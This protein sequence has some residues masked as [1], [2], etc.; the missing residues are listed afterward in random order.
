MMTRFKP[1]YQRWLQRKRWVGSRCPYYMRS[2]LASNIQRF[3]AFVVSQGLNPDTLG[4]F[5]RY[6]PCGSKGTSKDQRQVERR[7][8][9]RELR[10]LGAT[11]EQANLG[12]GS[13]FSL[14]RMKRELS[15]AFRDPG[16]RERCGGAALP[17]RHERIDP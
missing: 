5:A 13:T 17:P 8:R 12:A 11:P 9:Y 1:A 10:D 2:A 16:Q 3:R 4:D 7:A 6:T 15:G 14:A